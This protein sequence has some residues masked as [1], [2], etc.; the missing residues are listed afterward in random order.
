MITVNR[1]VYPALKPGLVA[2]C[3]KWFSAWFMVVLLY[4]D[5]WRIRRHL[6]RTEQELRRWDSSG[7]SPQLQVARA[8][9]LDQLN[10]YWRRRRFPRNTAGAAL[11]VPCFIDAQRRA[12]AV[13]HLIIAG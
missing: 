1:K 12:C 6:Q 10:L 5:D 4:L 11:Y 3:L 8:R 2:P 7:L 13:A 9:H